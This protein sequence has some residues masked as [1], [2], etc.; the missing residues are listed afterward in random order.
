MNRYRLIEVAALATLLAN[1]ITLA[2]IWFA[3]AASGNSV[4]VTVNQFGERTPELVLWTVFVP[5][6]AVALYRWATQAR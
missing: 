1:T 4:L 6:L 2:G 3:A 5:V